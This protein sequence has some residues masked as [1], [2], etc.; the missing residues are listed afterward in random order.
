M[1][2]KQKFNY[3]SNAPL[4]DRVHSII[5]LLEEPAVYEI[6]AEILELQGIASEEGVAECTL[7]IEEALKQL[8]EAGAVEKYF[9]NGKM[10]YKI[11]QNRFAH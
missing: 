6:T 10:R 11:N 4:K 5:S 1:A 2:D 7:N 9:D 8:I 3:P